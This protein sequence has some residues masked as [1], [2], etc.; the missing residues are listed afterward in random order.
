MPQCKRTSA[1]VELARSYQT[2]LT[3]S[4]VRIQ[5]SERRLTDKK[6]SLETVHAESTPELETLLL[7]FDESMV[8]KNEEIRAL[9][10]TVERAQGDIAA[11]RRQQDELN[12]QRGQAEGLREQLAIANH[13]LVEQ[14][15]LSADKLKMHRV[16]IEPGDWTSANALNLVRDGL[17]QVSCYD[18]KHH[19][20]CHTTFTTTCY[21]KY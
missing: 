11:E 7:N 20:S 2:E 16:T 17:S 3:E 19:V 4:R 5:E 6:A 12:I 9:Q 10:Q 14:S 13:H 15:L 21:Y 1:T 8:K 18:R